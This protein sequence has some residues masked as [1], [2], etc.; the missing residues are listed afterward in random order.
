M[1]IL[2]LFSILIFFIHN[3]YVSSLGTEKKTYVKDLFIATAYEISYV[4]LNKIPG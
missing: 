3:V 1:K 4:R 2:Y